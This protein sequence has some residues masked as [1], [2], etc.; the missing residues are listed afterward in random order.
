MAGDFDIRDNSWDPS[1]SFH[2]VYSDLLTD[3]ANFLD[4][5]LSNPTNQVSTRYLDNTN[6]S[7]LIID[8]MFLRPNSLEFN[9]Y[10]IYPEFQYS[11][12]HALLKVG[13]SIIKEFVLD[14]Q[15]K[16]IKNSEEENHFITEL[17]KAIK[18]I[19]TK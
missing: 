7:N 9:N 18:K 4:L 10:T 8:L 11:S 2:S 13:I 15:Y 6:D 5:L 14:K 17:I 1:I 12:D 16:I 19:N 3:V